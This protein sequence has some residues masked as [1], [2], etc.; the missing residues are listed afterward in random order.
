[1]AVSARSTITLPKARIQQLERIADL[2]GLPNSAALIESWIARS[3]AEGEIAEAVP[4]FSC[5]PFGDGFLISI[6][7][8]VLPVIAPDRA[9]LLAAVLSAVSGETDPKLPF[10]MPAG[11]PVVLDLGERK[12]AIGRAGRGVRFVLKGA[13]GGEGET[14]ATSPAFVSAL[15]RMIRSQFGEH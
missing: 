9:R 10:E 7:D 3:I 4:G 1:M 6:S 14:F 15:A 8:H 5:Q 2:R 12:L 11:R 13:D